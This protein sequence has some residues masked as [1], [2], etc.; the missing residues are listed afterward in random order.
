MIL[1]TIE[2]VLDEGDFRRW[3]ERLRERLSRLSP[4]STVHF[5]FEKSEAAWPASIDLLLTLERMLLRRSRPT[6]CDRV[7]PDAASAPLGAEASHDVVIDLTAGGGA[8]ARG[9]RVLRPLYDGQA[10]ELTAAAALL[11]G[12]CPTI[13][14]EDAKDGAIVAAGLP[15]LEAADGLTGGLEAVFT[16]VITLIEQ[17]LFSLSYTSEKPAAASAARARKGAAAFLLRNLAHQCARQIYH[18]ACHSPHWRVGWRFNDGPGAMDTGDLTGPPWNAL[19][20]LGDSFSADPFPVVWRGR[21]FIFFER[22]DYRTNKGTIAARE[23]DGRGPIGEAFD[24][25]EEPWHLS[26]PFLIAHGV[27]LYMLPEASASGAVSIYRCVEFPRQWECVGRLL[28]NIEAADATIFRHAGRF[29][30][31]SVVRDG[32][33]GYSDTLAIHHAAE[34]LGPWEEHARRPV[35]IDSR[36]ARPAGAVVERNGALLRPVQ[37]CS[38]GYGKRLV[39]M[40]IDALDPETFSQTPLAV[41]SPGP[42]WPGNRL[43]TLNRWGRLEC[44]DGAIVTPK[45]ATLRRLTHRAIGRV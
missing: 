3:H 19:D 4:Q 34:L 39:I 11:A 10:G 6:L 45:N 16:R 33:G 31:T 12:A 30:M 44:I 38:A 23:F 15:S 29:W 40:R 5:R 2:I 24:V 13:A 42:G 17:A 43:H 27:E 20:D 28:D 8:Q 18:L 21:T 22:L 25:I 14:L 32:A 9:A 35:L 1:S 26:Y 41:L 36:H 37:D 7:E